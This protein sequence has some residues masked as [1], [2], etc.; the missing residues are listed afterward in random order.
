MQVYVVCHMLRLAGG[1]PR[2]ATCILYAEAISHFFV[3]ETRREFCG[4]YVQSVCF[5]VYIPIML[6]M[7]QT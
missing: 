3:R 5:S 6:Y 1:L 7:M 2:N 4:I